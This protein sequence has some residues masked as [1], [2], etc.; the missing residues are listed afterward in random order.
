VTGRRL[1]GAWRGRDTRHVFTCS[2]HRLAPEW[3]GTSVSAEGKWERMEIWIRND[4]P[5]AGVDEARLRVRLT[6]A[7]AAVG[8]EDGELSVWLCDDAN[9][10]E[11]HREYMGVDTPTNVISFA[12][13]EGEFG[14]VEPEVLG[15][16][17]VSVDTAGRDARDAGTGL[18][19]EVLFLC[20]HG[21]LHL[22]GF[23]HEGDQASRAPEMEAKEMELFQLVCDEA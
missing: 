9:I 18:D 10:Q 3:T 22:L 8:C 23:D 6:R 20:I 17:V 14:D 4:C 11:L 5:E 12:Q 21:L 7:L 16:V 13:H 19:N 1:E 2:R 15:D